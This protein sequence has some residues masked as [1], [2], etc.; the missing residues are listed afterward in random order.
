M[1]KLEADVE[2]LEARNHGD[3]FKKIKE[4]NDRLRT[5]FEHRALKGDF[6]VNSR[7]MHYKFNPAAIAE[8]LADDKQKALLQEVETLRTLAASGNHSGVPAVSSLQA[9]GLSGPV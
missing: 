4:E 7:I 9:Q 6:N 2:S 3:E 1:T 8:Q 5:E